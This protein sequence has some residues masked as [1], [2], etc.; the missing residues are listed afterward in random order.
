MGLYDGSG[1]IIAS[2][3]LLDK[4]T[5]EKLSVNIQ[6]ISF[7]GA[8]EMQIT[9]TG[10]LSIEIFDVCG[11]KIKALDKTINT[12][13]NKTIKINNLKAGTY[14]II[15]KTETLNEKASSTQKVIILK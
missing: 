13:K 10:K 5:T 15:M 7:S 8:I 12:S 11:R 2:K 14:F 1:I 3:G 9:G 6:K 4:N